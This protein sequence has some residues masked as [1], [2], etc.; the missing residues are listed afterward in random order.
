MREAIGGAWL[1]Y[2]V[3]VFLLIYVFFMSFV[4]NYASTY[5]AANYVVT[6]IENCQAQNSDCSNKSMDE[7]YQEIRAKYRYIIPKERQNDYYICCKPNGN[8]SIYRVHL[9]VSF[10]V[11]LIGGITWLSVK[12]ETKTI[13]NVGCGDQKIGNIGL[14]SD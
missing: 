13:P 11:P 4:M 6:Q 14:C 2:L 7:V 5:R 12:S 3:V 10:D 1:Y 8:G 9:P